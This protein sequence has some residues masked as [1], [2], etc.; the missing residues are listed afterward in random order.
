MSGRRQHREQ[1]RGCAQQPPPAS[2]PPPAAE[3]RNS[4]KSGSQSVRA[5][6]PAFEECQGLQ[7]TPM[8]GEK[9]A[10]LLI[11]VPT[12]PFR[13]PF[14]PRLQLM[15]PACPAPYPTEATGALLRTLISMT[16]WE[17]SGA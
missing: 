7:G 14:K 16:T 13:N 2:L 9:D 3:H 17:D 4:P 12:N 11:S 8:Q 6:D 10:K 1:G 5:L 15:S